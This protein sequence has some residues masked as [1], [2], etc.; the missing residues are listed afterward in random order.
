MKTLLLETR[1]KKSR[2]ESVSSFLE[3]AFP[4]FTPA[5]YYLHDK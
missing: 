1:I 3:G 2:L 4:C 5:L